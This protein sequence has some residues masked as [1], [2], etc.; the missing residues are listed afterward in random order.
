MSDNSVAGIEA[1]PG[2]QVFVD[3]TKISHNASYGIH[4][5]GGVTLANSDIVFNNSSISG[6]TMSYGNNRLYGNG[7]GD[8]PSPISQ[9]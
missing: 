5:L 4:A 6:A 8:A 9:Q 7:A 1:D 3:T 2:A